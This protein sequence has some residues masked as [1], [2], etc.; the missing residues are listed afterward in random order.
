MICSSHTALRY[1]IVYRTRMVSCLLQPARRLWLCLL[2]LLLFTSACPDSPHRTVVVSL[3]LAPRISHLFLLSPSVAGTH[4]HPKNEMHT[5]THLTTDLDFFR[6]VAN[7]FC[8]A[9]PDTQLPH[10]PHSPRAHSADRACES[11]TAG[12]DNSYLYGAGARLPSCHFQPGAT[13]AVHCGSRVPL[14]RTPENT[15]I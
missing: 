2:L 14:L 8:P 10:P 9:V 12:C 13:M 6:H 4:G 11:A 7:C 1:R 15:H 5:H 3:A